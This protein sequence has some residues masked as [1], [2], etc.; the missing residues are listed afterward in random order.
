MFFRFANKF[1]ADLEIVP[2]WDLFM[3]KRKLQLL[4]LK[5]S[6]LK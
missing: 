6:S 2:A 4:K 3:G 1:L 5:K